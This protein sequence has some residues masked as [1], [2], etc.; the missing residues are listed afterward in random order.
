MTP[1]PNKRTPDARVGFPPERPPD[2]ATKQS[3]LDLLRDWRAGSAATATV[4]AAL[5][6]FAVAWHD[7]YLTAITASLIGAVTVAAGCHAARERRLAILAIF[8]EFAHVADLARKRT[9]LVST[10]TR[11]ALADGLRRTADP[12]QPPRRFD[13]CPVLPDRVAV[14][15][16]ELLQLAST[17]EQTPN[18][19]AASVAL[20]HELLTNACS[21][22][23][24]PSRPADDLRRSLSRAQAGI[25]A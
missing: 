13:C 15:R 3:G 8:P 9:R 19:D 1:G 20:I 5:L 4:M 6:P 25:V 14:V 21:P 23:Y 16:C 7:A 12:T 10:C 11:Q 18:P 2:H 17:L 22:L 24:N